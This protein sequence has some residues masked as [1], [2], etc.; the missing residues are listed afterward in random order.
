MHV[1]CH[2]LSKLLLVL[3][4]SYNMTW[5]GALFFGCTEQLCLW[6]CCGQQSQSLTRG[7]EYQ[8][9]AVY[10]IAAFCVHLSATLSFLAFEI[11]KIR[12]FFLCTCNETVTVSLEF[13]WQRFYWLSC[14]RLGLCTAVHIRQYVCWTCLTAYEDKHLLHQNSSR[15]SSFILIVCLIDQPTAVR[16]L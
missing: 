10:S 2:W 16:C 13:D 9:K 7:I 15:S 11:S 6:S 3:S 5:S 12:A 1:T 8:C 4:F 14:S